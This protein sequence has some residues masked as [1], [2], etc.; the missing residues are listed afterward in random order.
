MELAKKDLYWFF[1]LYFGHYIEFE[2][3][4]FQ[5]EIFQKVA[6]NSIEHLV[7]VAFRGSGKSTIVSMAFPLWA[8]I[9]A[10]QKKYIVIVSQTQ[11]QAQQHLRNFR[12][13]V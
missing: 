10:M 12:A 2:T 8:M 7:I 9:G 6:D 4:D 5:R 1:H 3:A 13:E 11:Q